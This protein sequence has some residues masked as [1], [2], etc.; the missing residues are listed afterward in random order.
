ME[1]VCGQ[2]RFQL[3]V[4]TLSDI[5]YRTDGSNPNLPVL[6]NFIILIL[7]ILERLCEYAQ[8]VPE[9]AKNN[10]DINNRSSKNLEVGTV[11]WFTGLSGSGK[12]L[13]ENCFTVTYVR[14][15][16]MLSF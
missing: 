6:I 11:Y 7:L 5:M 10:L 1:E 2:S 4:V 16:R 8:L 9:N 13:L 15:N 3:M 14:S 12:L